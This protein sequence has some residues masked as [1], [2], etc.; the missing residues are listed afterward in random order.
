MG[1]FYKICMVIAKQHFTEMLTGSTVQQA[2]KS[3][4]ARPKDPQSTGSHREEAIDDLSKHPTGFVSS[5]FVQQP[6][7]PFWEPPVQEVQ[8]D[9][10]TQTTGDA[11]PAESMPSEEPEAMN[12]KPLGE[13]V[14]P[15]KPKKKPYS[16][17]DTF[18][19]DLFGENAHYKVITNERRLF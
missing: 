7:G 10:T 19:K 2:L 5:P 4:M 13:I 17:P 1:K 14:K 3:F 11:T 15:T 8:P 9:E 18:I 12:D 16:D 6:V